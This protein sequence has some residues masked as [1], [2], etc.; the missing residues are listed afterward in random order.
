MDGFGMFSAAGSAVAL[1]GVRILAMVTGS[2][3]RT[4]VEQLFVNRETQPIEAV[5]TYPLPDGAAVCGFEAVTGDRVLTGVM[6]ELD[7][8]IEKYEE[9]VRAGGAAFLAEMWRPDVFSTRVGNLKPEQAVLIRLTYVAEAALADSTLRLS[10]PLTLAPRYGTATGTSDPITAA[11]ETDAL[12]PPHVL[13]VP[14]GLDF[15]ATVD[16]GARIRSLGSPS[17]GVTVQAAEGT[18]AWKVRLLGSGSLMN[19][20]LVLEIQLAKEPAAS[21]RLEA[22]VAGG[23]QFVAV[24]FVPTFE[25][26]EMEARVGARDVV[27]VLDCSGSMEGPSM[28]QA[29]RALALCL[30]S[31]DEGDR[32]NICR[33]GSTHQWMFRE[34]EVYAQGTLDRALRYLSET[35][36][37]LGGTELYGPLAEAMTFDG[38][39]LR[40]VV[41]LTDGQVS[42][43]PALVELAR[44]HKGRVRLFT[45]GIGSA[46]SAFLIN[47]LA[48]AT[49]G[50]SEFIAEGERIEEKVLRTFARMNS[51][52][53]EA[54][55][56]DFGGCEAIVAPRDLPALFDGDFASLTARVLGKVPPHTVTVSGRLGGKL[57]TWKVPVFAAGGVEAGKVGVIGARWVRSRIA[58]LEAEGLD[59]ER[60]GAVVGLSKKYGVLCKE[61]TLVALEHRSA[62]ERTSGMPALRRVPVM[63]AQGW[64]GMDALMDSAKTGFAM[65]AQTMPMSPPCVAP[66]PSGG[67]GAG[68][69]AFSKEL[70]ASGRLDEA[71]RRVSSID[72]GAPMKKASANRDASIDIKADELTHLLMQQM[73]AGHFMDDRLLRAKSLNAKAFDG[74]AWMRELAALGV[75]GTALATAMTLAV[76]VVCFADKADLWRPAFK[77]GMR[78][79]EKHSPAA[80]GWVEGH[81]VAAAG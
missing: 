29:R 43:E 17:H 74:G 24:D 19:R 45:F 16:V 58:E 46:P 14:Y 62:A 42:N 35:G 38:K 15:A 50:A 33:F 30:K 41:V 48:R 66:A 9:A 59:V 40:D 77:K 44:Q 78:W 61:T 65:P 27:F 71:V 11:V 18:G 52:R 79:L 54:V 23:E 28:E 51:P 80:K 76:L 3:H 13:A 63:L 4:V 56:V 75:G 20:D 22:G 37:D 73:A 72:R 64:G 47:G 34:A 60:K 53:L 2:G 81:V 6:E 7:A 32:F 5:Y 25:E 8:G 31:L 68:K 69:P 26:E 55:A 21:A 12:N 1:T 70:S 10:F 57:K 36:A 49:G 67:A 39:A